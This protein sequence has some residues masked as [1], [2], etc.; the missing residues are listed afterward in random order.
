[1]SKTIIKLALAATAIVAPNLSG[2]NLALNGAEAASP[3]DASVKKAHSWARKGEKALAKGDQIK[4]LMYVEQAVEADLQ[5]RDYRALLAQVYMAQGRFQSAERTLMDVM[6]LGQVDPRTVISLSLARIAQG[7]V[8]SAISLVE[9]NRS[10]IPASDY[11]LTLALAGQPSRGVEV[12]TEAIRADNATARTRQNLALAYALDGRWREARIMAVQDMPQDAVNERVAEWAQYARPGAYETR[13]AGLLN[14]TPQTDSGQ[15]VRL[16]L[17]AVPTGVQQQAAVTQQP[18]PTSA[19]NTEL[20][21]IGLA[22][23]ALSKGFDA[24]PAAEESV[25]IVYVSNAEATVAATSN[26]KPLIKAPQGP[27]KSASTSAVKV[28]M[29]PAAKVPAA[30]KPVKL[31]LADVEPKQ[32][33]QKSIAGTHL[34]QLGAF[35]NAANAQQGW[36]ALSAKYRVL[37]GFSSASLAVNVKGKQLIRLAA[38][39]F[40]NQASAEA[41][42]NQIKAKGGSCIVRSISGEQPVRL[43]SAAPGRKGTTGRGL[44]RKIAVR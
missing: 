11:G 20:A 14:V 6:E 42:C 33:P 9:A 10:I 3:A 37:D 17:N 31:A 8:E 28:A 4:A 5:N 43:A 21:A 30:V 26:E 41:V 13:V 27:A 29:A 34:I 44:S 39:G 22:P 35:S 24:A 1:M 12:L 23:A 2:T 32:A 18:A 25:R 7:R 19:N 16:A 36:K 15:P 40:G 38:L